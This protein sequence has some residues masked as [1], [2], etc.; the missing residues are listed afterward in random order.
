M[1]GLRLSII[2]ITIL[3]AIG[4]LIGWGIANLVSGTENAPEG[5][6]EPKDGLIY[7]D[8]HFIQAITPTCYPNIQTLG[9]LAERII[10]CESRGTHDVCNKQYGC[11]AGMG[12]FQLIPKTVEYCEGKLG[13]EIDPFD[14][15]DNYECGMWLL[16]NEGT[17][18]WG[19]K[20][21]DWGSYDCWN[22]YL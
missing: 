17:Q 21:T 11:G 1:D 18:H 19:T 5:Q 12:L 3:L 14:P 16:K 6:L 13:K 10:W 9:A 7:S 2:F 4:A 15:D 20:D 22:E 8:K